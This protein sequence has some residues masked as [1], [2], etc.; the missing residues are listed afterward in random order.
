M[1]MSGKREEF[2]VPTT[3]IFV[4]VHEAESGGSRG[5]EEGSET[6]YSAAER[7]SREATRYGSSA[8]EDV[9]QSAT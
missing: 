2:A 8:R 3:S 4:P 6:L 1:K 9:S 5:V 7:L